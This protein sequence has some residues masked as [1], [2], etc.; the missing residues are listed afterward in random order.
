[1]LL[2][3]QQE[4]EDFKTKI[5]LPDYLLQYHGFEK[6]SKQSSART[7]MLTNGVDKIGITQMQ[8]GHWITQ[9]TLEFHDFVGCKQ[10]L[11]QDLLSYRC[12]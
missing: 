11:I 3:S 1:M 5:N 4:I 12:V 6:I 2:N 7:Q 9:T 10:D 8:N